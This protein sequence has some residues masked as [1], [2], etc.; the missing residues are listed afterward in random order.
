LYKYFY[1]SSKNLTD[2]KKKKKFARLNGYPNAY[3]VGFKNGKLFE[4][5]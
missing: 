5:D 4:V 2:I 1:S 3:I